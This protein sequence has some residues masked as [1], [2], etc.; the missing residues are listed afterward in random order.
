M[1]FLIVEDDENSRILL[2]T[3]LREQGY[4]VDSATNGAQALVM[5]YRTPP[6]MIISDILMPEMDGYALC[7][8][9]KNDEQLK[10]IPFIF[11]TATYLETRDEQ[12]A[13]SLG[14][15]RYIIKPMEMVDFLKIIAEVLEEHGA[16]KLSIPEHPAKES[17][18]LDQMHTERLANKLDKK[19]RELEQEREALRRSESHLRALFNALPD[20][21]WLKDPDGVYLSCNLK[22]ERFFGAKETE[23][24]GKTDYDFVDKNLADFFREKDMAA[25]SAGKP[26]VNEE[27]ITYAD[28]GHKEVLETVKTPMFDAYGKLVGVLGIAHDITRRKE[29][30][31]ERNRLLHETGEQ[32]KKLRCMYGLAE[33]ISTR[34]T[35][36][37]VLEDAVALI[38]P[39]WHYPKITRA[40]LRFDE[41]EYI[42]E[43]FEETEWT[44]SADIVVD[45]ERR[46]TLEVFYLEEQPELDE[47]PFFFE[48]RNLVDGMSH[49]LS[50]AIGHVQAEQQLRQALKMDAVG[51]LT[52]GIAHDF[53]N[54]L[55]I[56]LGNLDLLKGDIPGEID[57]LRRI[58]A[59]QK[60]TQR[61]A[62]LT[63][64]LLGFSRRRATQVAVT[65]I[66]QTIQDMDS[67][68]ARSVIP[69][70]EV[71][72]SF[73]E[74]LWLTEIDSGDFQDALLN[75]IIN[76]RDA[77]HGG[78][79]LILKT[80][81]KILD[82]TY[83]ALNPGAIPGEYIQ[84]AVSDNGAGIPSKLQEHIFEPFYSTKEQGK[85]TGLGLA[86][87]YGFVKRSGGYIKVYSESG[88]GTTF[89]IY[90]PRALG[91]KQSSDA[92]EIPSERL[93]GGT[94]T[95]LAV[96]DEEG[97]L[98][99]V[100]SSLQ[101]QGYRV[102]TVTSGRQ[103]LEKLAEE[104]G[105]DL[106]FS[107]VVMPGGM[108]G[109]ELAERA[110][111][112]HPGLKVL[113]TSGYTEKTLANNSQARFTAD[114]LIK[115][116]TMTDLTKRIRT[117][118]GDSGPSRIGS[119]G[120]E[121]GEEQPSE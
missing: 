45:G 63:K 52:G 14:A 3:T 16:G 24:V 23:I 92:S 93:P 26:A 29:A 96:D 31:E 94:E 10:K 98:E 33:S 40:R 2:K 121:M 38:P 68:I 102:V 21:I 95:I 34:E 75:L 41:Q 70:V 50:G 117:L 119:G 113:L 4:T 60:S 90:L 7:R 71:E 44:L 69:H 61:A 67:L 22:F 88:I 65:D 100:Q 64:Q 106:L 55:G 39:A 66:Q 59:I 80:T 51:Q 111:D 86:L 47:G 108:N 76:A 9:V 43:P 56:I 18:E 87:V 110:S 62:D 49:A 25:I 97:L 8:E 17:H 91:K 54:I 1:R 105:V 35:L 58:E 42:S 118:L 83:C 112:N 37:Q 120:L 27:E 57:A 46:G 20:L 73:T 84:L 107:D 85:G 32:V 13:L 104:P 28:D 11:Y 77:M 103:A 74:G 12:L 79:R 115:P 19:V 30:Y 89:R 15:S 72:L 82:A 116:Y 53:N 99:L 81:N 5:A 114:L 48:E 78:G 36:E 101:V 109:Y 6:D